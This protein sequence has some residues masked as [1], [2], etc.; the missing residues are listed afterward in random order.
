MGGSVQVSEF[1]FENRPKIVLYQYTVLIFW[2]IIV[3]SHYDL[4][5]L[6]MS[7]M[8]IL[9]QKFGVGVTSSIQFFL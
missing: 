6:S 2:S 3:V 5:V 4:S 8:G 1:F 9:K 7:V